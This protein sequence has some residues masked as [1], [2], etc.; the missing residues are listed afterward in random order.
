MNHNITPKNIELIKTICIKNGISF[1][2]IQVEAI[3][4]IASMVETRWEMFPNEDF[5]SALDAVIGKVDWQPF[6]YKND[7]EINTMAWWELNVEQKKVQVA[8]GILFLGVLLLGIL[9]YGKSAPSDLFYTCAL[10]AFWA[11]IVVYA[12]GGVFITISFIKAKSMLSF[13]Y[14]QKYIR[15]ILGA[16]LMIIQISLMRFSKPSSYS[17]LLMNLIAQLAILL[18]FVYSFIKPIVKARKLY[19]QIFKS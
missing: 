4:H 11:A 5:E 13:A 10:Y 15:G 1:Y 16:I 3:D 6:R 18:V 17:L 2:D 19:P 12:L 7:K 8:A 14:K 9:P